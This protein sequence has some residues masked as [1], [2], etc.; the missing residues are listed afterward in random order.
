MTILPR[1]AKYLFTENSGQV[2]GDAVIRALGGGL[3]IATGI[4]HLDLWLTGYRAIPTIGWMF[5]VQFTSAL[6]LG[7]V[8]VALVFARETA[9]RK[10]VGYFSWQEIVSGVGAVLSFGTLAAYVSALGVGLFGYR[11]FRTTAGVLAAALEIVTFVLLGRLACEGLPPGTPAGILRA[12]TT[13]VA[14]TLLVVAESAG[15]VPAVAA[16]GLAATPPRHLAGVRGDP[17][18]AAVVTIVIKGFAFQPADP[19]VGPGEQILVK[20]EDPVAHTLSAP[21]GTSGAGAFSTGTI[22]AGGSARLTAPARAG[23]YAFICLVH[24][25]MKGTLT[26]T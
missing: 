23:H 8:L 25:F 9:N 5:A 17:P 10:A 15:V 11:E 16:Q 4:D 2:D 24:P 7:L 22:A 3:L 14:V 19:K 20:N 13:S 12:V 1:I 26:V 21:P 6:V 18:P